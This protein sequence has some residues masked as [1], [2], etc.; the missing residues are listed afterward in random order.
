VNGWSCWRF[1]VWKWAG[2]LALQAERTPHSAWSFYLLQDVVQRVFRLR[3]GQAEA[4][5]VQT[6]AGEVAAYLAEYATGKDGKLYSD[7]TV[8]IHHP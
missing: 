2:D 7:A 5:V 6:S 3:L 4:E 8:E 1:A